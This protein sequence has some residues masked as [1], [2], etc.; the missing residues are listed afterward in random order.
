MN[1]KRN[2]KGNCKTPALGGLNLCCA[3]L[4]AIGLQVWFNVEAAS[5]NRSAAPAPA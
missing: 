3:V 5:T 2:G 4:V 1:M